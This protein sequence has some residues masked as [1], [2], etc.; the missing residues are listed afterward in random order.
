MVPSF[1][2]CSKPPLTTAMVLP[3]G[4][5]EPETAGE[6]AHTVARHFAEELHNP[7]GFTYALHCGMDARLERAAPPT[8]SQERTA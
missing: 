2:V 6:A 1:A 7:L 4:D 3:V 5:E 8:D